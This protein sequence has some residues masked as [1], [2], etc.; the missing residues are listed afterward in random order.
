MT[1]DQLDLVLEGLE[2]IVGGTDQDGKLEF[3]GGKWPLSQ[4]IEH[5]F[6]L[7]GIANLRCCKPFGSFGLSQLRC[8]FPETFP[9]FLSLFT[10][11]WTMHRYMTFLSTHKTNNDFGR[12][13]KGRCHGR[14][15]CRGC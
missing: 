14:D 2:G 7:T 11:I 13:W 12:S 10:P 3:I 5:L 4:S 8:L 6:T 1:R 15:R 9:S